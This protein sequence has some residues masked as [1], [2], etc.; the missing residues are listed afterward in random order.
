M[1]RART[2]LIWAIGILFIVIGLLKDI[3]LDEI[4]TPTLTRAHFPKWFT[5]VVG[6]IE[7]VGGLL[8]LMA[9]TESKRLGSILIGLVMAGAIG[10]RLLLHEP[11]SHFLLP[12]AILIIAILTVI[13]P[14]GKPK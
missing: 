6:T 3:N 7:F 10:T 12:G 9:A 5:Y 14:A 4:T 8:M 2:I 13:N 11:Y 1:K